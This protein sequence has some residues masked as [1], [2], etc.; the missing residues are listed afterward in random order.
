MR[1]NPLGE[2]GELGRPVKLRPTELLNRLRTV[3]ADAEPALG[4]QQ[5]IRKRVAL[6]ALDAIL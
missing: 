4:R 6:V 5:D 2:R 1:G 3:G